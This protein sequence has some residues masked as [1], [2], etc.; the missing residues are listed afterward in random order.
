MLHFF[1]S[2]SKTTIMITIS[3]YI[4]NWLTG[5]PSILF[6]RFAKVGET[7]I[8]ESE[9]VCK[10]IVGVDASQLSPFPM[11]KEMPTGLYTKW[12][13]NDDTAKFHPK[14]NW[15]SL[16]E[17]QVIYYLQSTRHSSVT[18]NR[19]EL[20]LIPSMASALIATQC[21]RQ[22]DATFTFLPV[23]KKSSCFLKI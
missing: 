6:T 8:R 4:R 21:L 15:R 2:A 12:E 22:C 11:T 1:H 17:Q 18:K 5:G 10:T 20:E 14:R 13:F 23:R 16:F 3:E 7:K 9:K 19:K